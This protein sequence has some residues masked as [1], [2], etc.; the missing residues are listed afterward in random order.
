MSE[1][2]DSLVRMKGQSQSKSYFIG[3]ERGRYWASGVGDYFDVR[4]WSEFGGSDFASVSLP[5]DEDSHFHVLKAETELEWAQYVKG[6]LDG[7]REAARR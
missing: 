4:Q 5:D 2:I 3:L 1:I 6:W 7:V